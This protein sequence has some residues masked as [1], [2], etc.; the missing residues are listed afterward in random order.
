MNGT[1]EWRVLLEG[2]Y[3]PPTAEPPPSEGDIIVLRH[4]PTP[5]VARV[6]Q[7]LPKMD[8]EEGTL[9]VEGPFVR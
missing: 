3:R 4:G 2:T 5:I 1:R 8:G 6:K 7:I 9:V